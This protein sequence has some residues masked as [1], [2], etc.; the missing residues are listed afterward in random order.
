M[1][2]IFETLAYVW[3]TFSNIAGVVIY[4]KYDGSSP[5]GAFFIDGDNVYYA[6]FI[7]EIDYE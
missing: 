6:G 5:N 2:N 3:L 4:T 7:G 1:K